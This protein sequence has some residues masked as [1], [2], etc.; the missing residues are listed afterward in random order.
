MKYRR[1][2]SENDQVSIIGFGCMRLPIIDNQY[3]KIDEEEVKK[4]LRCAIDKG[5]NYV[6]TA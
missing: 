5:V 3:D 1:L 2:G 4:Q 6:D